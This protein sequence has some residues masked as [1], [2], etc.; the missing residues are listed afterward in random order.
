M[1]SAYRVNLDI[2]DGPMDLLLY[3]IKRDEVDI[4]DISLTHI[5][6]QYIHYVELLQAVEPNLSGEF[7]VLAATLMEIK[8][9]MLLPV[10]EI[11]SDD[12]D[13]LGLDPRA[14]LIRQLLQYKAF[15]DA[16]ND[17]GDLAE[18][19]SHRFPRR[20]GK[21]HLDDTDEVDL[22]DVQ[23]WDLYDAFQKVLDAIGARNQFQTDIIYD[24]TPL[25]L[26]QED[27]LDRLGRDGDLTFRQV[28]KGRTRR[29]EVVGLFIATLELMRQQK[30]FVQQD[31]EAEI[32]IKLNP[33]PPTAEDLAAVDNQID[34]RFAAEAVDQDMQA[35]AAAEA[36]ANAAAKEDVL[37]LDEDEDDD[38]SWE[39]DEEEWDEDDELDEEFRRVMN[40]NE[41]ASA[42]DAPA[43]NETDPTEPEISHDD[44]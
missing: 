15:K 10:E 38:E 21:V 44:Q 5:T 39:D 17:L 7:L 12:E 26:H 1:T 16:A 27:I 25:Y 30:V 35:Q 41:P 14:D 3:L 28:F 42:T 31:E 18:S 32:H 33:N 23:I 22:D 40:D 11:E 24:D 9:R 13:E 36:A 2:Y 19:Q 29:T 8:T 34:E 6:K 4:Q 37:D 43:A 20:P